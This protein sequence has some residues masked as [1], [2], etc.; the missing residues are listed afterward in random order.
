MNKQE[1]INKVKEDLVARGA[2]VKVVKRKGLTII[3]ARF[4]SGRRWDVVKV[5]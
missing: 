3:Q 1:K 2:K 5:L 4:L